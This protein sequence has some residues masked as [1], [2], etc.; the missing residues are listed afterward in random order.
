MRERFFTIR[1]I[2]IVVISSI[3]A[4]ILHG[5]TSDSSTVPKEANWSFFVNILGFPVTAALY[6]FIAFGVISYIFYRYEEN[7]T[8][9]KIEK[10]I[11]YG[12]GIGL[13]WLWGMLEGVGIWGNSLKNELVTGICDFIPILVMSLLLGIC[14]VKS[15]IINKKK[16]PTNLG[17]MFLTIFIFSAIFFIGRYVL[18]YTNTI[19]SGYLTSP[20]FTF[21]WT[22]LMGVCIG[23]AYI[24]LG[25]T[26]QSSSPLLSALK[27]GV[28][29]F[30]VNWLVFLIFIPLIFN[31]FLIDTTI[32]IASD[33]LLVTL[34]YY[35][36]HLSVELLNN[37]KMRKLYR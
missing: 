16:M 37:Q 30:G 9:Q 35:L 12:I 17:N 24:L 36:S 28:I 33:I 21:I 27:F 3:L 11:R 26:T 6:F 29:V 2:T 5:L 23:I 32:R 4:I 10:G 13:L 22:I 34:S 18:Y 1:Y 31:D 19:N 15:N 25:Q 8:G 7:I 14:T 20:S